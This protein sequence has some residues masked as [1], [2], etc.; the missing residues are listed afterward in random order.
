MAFWSVLAMTV[1]IA[2]G[3]LFANLREQILTLFLRRWIAE[4]VV[5]ARYQSDRVAFH[6]S[7]YIEYIGLQPKSIL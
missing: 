1:I 4:C 3:V 7:P 6:A 2:L 5:K